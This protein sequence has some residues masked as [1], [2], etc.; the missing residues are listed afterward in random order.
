MPII[1]PISDLRNCSNEIS[2]LCRSSSRPIFIA[3]NGRIIEIR[4]ILRAKQQYFGL[5]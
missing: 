5:I 4:R 2:E 1:R 3:K